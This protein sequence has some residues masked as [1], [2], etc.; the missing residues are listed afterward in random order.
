F[1]RMQL[2]PLVALSAHLP[3]SEHLRADLARFAPRGTLT[4]GRLRWVGTAA[5]PTSFTASADFKQLGL[6]AQ[7]AFPG[8]TG[9]DGRFEATHESGEIRLA[10]SHV[11]L[12][13]PR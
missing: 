8:V 11:T 1:D 10:G 4:Q 13:L 3:L 12:D 5:A 6:L 9:L 7:D 2:A